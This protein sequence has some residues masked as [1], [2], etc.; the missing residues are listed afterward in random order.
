[1]L[2]KLWY[3]LC[4]FLC[5]LVCATLIGRMILHTDL[6]LHTPRTTVQRAAQRIPEAEARQIVLDSGSLTTLLV[7]QLP[8]DFPLTDLSIQISSSNQL[9]CSA[10]LQP[11]Q[12]DLPRAATALL[13]DRCTLSAV[14]SI[15]YADDALVLQATRLKLGGLLLPHTLLSP[16]VKSL[17]DALTTGLQAQGIQL[18]SLN[19]QDEKLCIGLAP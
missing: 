10:Q 6:P 18:Q 8:A 5:V 16:I 19:V 9:L 13:P 15:G 17:S 3:P 7:R 14:I 1:M 4:M 2:Q 12:L 11:A